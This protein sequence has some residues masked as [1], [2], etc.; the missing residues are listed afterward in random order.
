VDLK[1]C[2]YCGQCNEACE[3]HAIV[4]VKESVLTF[5]ELCHGCGACA[6]VCPQDAIHE[7]GR[8]IGRIEIGHAGKIRFIHGILNVG[9]PMATPVIR[10][11]KALM[12]PSDI[13]ILDAPPGTSC[14]V[15]ETVRGSDVCLLVTEPTPFGLNDLELAAGMVKKMGVPMGVVINRADRGDQ[16]VEDFCRREEIPVLMKIPMDRKIA[17]LYS[18]GIPIVENLPAYRRKFLKLFEEIR[19]LGVRKTEHVEAQ[20]LVGRDLL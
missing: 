8:E 10:R 11:E 14:P 13:T 20:H 3:F 16:G 2:T 1:K 15:I 5:D 4:V 18:R 19:E 9:E 12:D 17:E 7:I 6:Y